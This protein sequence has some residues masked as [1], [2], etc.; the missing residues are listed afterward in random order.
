MGITL[1]SPLQP[2]VKLALIKGEEIVLN[3]EKGDNRTVGYN[4]YKTTKESFFK[5][6]LKVFK[7]IQDIR[8]VDSDIVR[9]FNYTYEIEAFDENG[10]VSPKIHM[11]TLKMEKLK[12]K[13]KIEEEK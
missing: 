11:A 10:L 9:G 3:W 12:K 1:N 2:N 8:Y 13:I 5:N 4:I 6:K 7:N